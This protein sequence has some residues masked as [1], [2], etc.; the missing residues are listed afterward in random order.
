M[1]FLWLLC[2]ELAPALAGCYHYYS[3]TGCEFL[4]K[5]DLT[6]NFVG[7][8]L[9]VEGLK[10]NVHLEELY[11]TGNPCTDYEGYREYVV[12]TLP[13]LKFLD[14]KEIT[15]S[16][17]ILAQQKLKEVCKKIA[18]QQKAYQEKR[19]R[20]KREYEEKKAK[21]RRRKDKDVGYGENGSDRPGFNKRWYTDPSAHLEGG[22]G[23]TKDSAEETNQGEDDQEQRR[24]ESEGEEEEGFMDET[25][26]YTPESRVETSKYIAEQRKAKGK[27]VE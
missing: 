26:A 20:E 12:A 10:R 14:G 4:Q 22:A 9:S 7:D 19:E 5:L 23:K 21:G 3:H 27:E 25:T 11:L 16:E 17:R 18:E 6:V 2:I 15:K 24:S 1:F 13:Q 8:L